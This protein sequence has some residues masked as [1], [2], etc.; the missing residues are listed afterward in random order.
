MDEDRKELMEKIMYESKKHFTKILWRLPNLGQL[1][2]RKDEL[3]ILLILFLNY[4][5]ITQ[6]SS[7][8]SHASLYHIPCI[9]RCGAHPCFATHM[10]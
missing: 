10:F 2:W 6:V 7:N 8:T 9:M 5:K 3:N 1:I 4:L